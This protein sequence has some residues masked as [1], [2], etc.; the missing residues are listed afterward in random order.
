MSYPHVLVIQ[1]NLL[2][3]EKDLDFVASCKSSIHQ[4][5]D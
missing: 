2:S 1:G 4:I 3:K 5:G